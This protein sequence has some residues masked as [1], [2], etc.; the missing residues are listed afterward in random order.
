MLPAEI[1][2]ELIRASFTRESGRSMSESSRELGS[3]ALEEVTRSAF[4]GVLRA[5]EARNLNI[6]QFPG[7]IL[8]G[9]IAWP[10]LSQQAAR[11][12]SA[13]GQAPTG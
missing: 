5:V 12:G 10:E 8:V 9:I 13:G 7:P 2:G 6:D 11:L 4:N 1:T 3:A